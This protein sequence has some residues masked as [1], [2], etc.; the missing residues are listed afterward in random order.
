MG[1]GG[2]TSAAR[3]FCFKGHVAEPG[4]GSKWLEARQ[5]AVLHGS[6]TEVKQYSVC[7]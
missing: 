1:G 2:K 7:A 4:R 3:F 5:F 6:V